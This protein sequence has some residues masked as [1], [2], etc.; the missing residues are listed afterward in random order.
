MPIFLGFL[1]PAQKAISLDDAVGAIT[2]NKTL[3]PAF[4]PFVTLK[5]RFAGRWPE[6]S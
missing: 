2:G 4:V 1:L 5:R 3:R 6:S